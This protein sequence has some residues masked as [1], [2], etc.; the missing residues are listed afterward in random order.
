MITCVQVNQR[1]P[2][3]LTPLHNA[4]KA[5]D[6]QCVRL[7]LAAGADVLRLDSTPERN[8]CLHIAAQ[9]GRADVIDELLGDG[10]WITD[11]KG[12]RKMLLRH[13]GF[14][15]PQGCHKVRWVEVG[16]ALHQAAG[17]LVAVRHANRT[18]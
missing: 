3:G 14:A 6:V 17:L 11:A 10:S 13:A 8:S 2:D 5:G 7:L 1:D 18:L 9:Y 4:C 12:R 16:Q 15:G